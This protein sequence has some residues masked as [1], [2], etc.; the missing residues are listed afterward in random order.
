MIIRS[1]QKQQQQQADDDPFHT[2]LS[3]ATCTQE[4][5]TSKKR[6]HLRMHELTHQNQEGVITP[7]LR[8]A[9]LG[10]LF[11]SRLVFDYDY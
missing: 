2:C 10:S 9:T 7:L 5:R 6:T 1:F 3:H 4:Q 8:V 11:F